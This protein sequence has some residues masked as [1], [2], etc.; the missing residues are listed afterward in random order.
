M[1]Q[2]IP[3]LFYLLILK[4]CYYKRLIILAVTTIVFHY[5]FSLYLNKRARFSLIVFQNLAFSN[6]I[7]TNECDSRSKSISSIAIATSLWKPESGFRRLFVLF[8]IAPIWAFVFERQK[9]PEAPSNLQL[10]NSVRTANAT[11]FHET[12]TLTTVWW[13]TLNGQLP[14]RVAEEN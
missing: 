2:S 13:Q 1:F 11:V 6:P 5:C 12:Q 10:N 7:K 4:R 3:C 8:R 14:K 9:L